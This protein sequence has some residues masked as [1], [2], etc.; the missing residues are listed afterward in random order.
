MK[1]SIE[2]YGQEV[3][4]LPREVEVRNSIFLEPLHTV[5]RHAVPIEM[6]VET[7]L[8][9]SGT[10]DLFTKFGI[11]VRDQFEFRVMKSRFNESIASLNVVQN[12]TI[13]KEG[14]IIFFPL[15]NTY[16]VVRYVE[17]EDAFYQLNK[18]YSWLLKTENFEYSSEVFSTGNPV[19]DALEWNR[20]P[21]VILDCRITDNSFLSGNSP[22]IDE[23]MIRDEFLNLRGSFFSQEI[24]N[25]TTTDL[26]LSSKLYDV[27]SV[28]KNSTLVDTW[29]IRLKLGYI[30][31]NKDLEETEEN[32]ALKYDSKMFYPSST[33]YLISTINNDIQ[34]RILRVVNF[35]NLLPV[36]TDEENEEIA[37]EFDELPNAILDNQSQNDV[38]EKEAEKVVDFSIQNPFG[39]F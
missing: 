26:L 27:V 23:E 29:D 35:E 18:V 21:S 28:I 16:F 3:Y 15:M 30:H 14:D 12:P 22:P 4:Y 38:L 11:D 9:M 1:E 10:Q 17:D 13:P 39:N 5:Y 20:A 8:G 2:I 24:S 31:F 32:E 6:Y 7:I 19:I 33:K 36:N 37:N 25:S 34:L